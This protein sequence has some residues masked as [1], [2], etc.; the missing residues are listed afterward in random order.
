LG[1]LRVKGLRVNVGGVWK[2]LWDR[3]AKKPYTDDCCI[4]CEGDDYWNLATNPI[5]A[6]PTA[7]DDPGDWWWEYSTQTGKP[8]GDVS[9]PATPS[10]RGGVA[11]HCVRVLI[12]DDAE[13][14][15]ATYSQLDGEHV[16]GP[17]LSGTAV[18]DEAWSHN[19]CWNYYHFEFDDSRPGDFFTQGLSKTFTVD[20]DRLF[21]ALRPDL[22]SIPANTRHHVCLLCVVWKLSLQR[23]DAP[24]TPERIWYDQGNVRISPLARWRPCLE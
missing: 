5:T 23:M 22:C 17:W 19:S 14:D 15:G 7:G 21:A 4:C 3:V 24:T 6:T 8:V 1:E 10:Y 13:H 20:A 16:L 18:P 11:P 12:Y 2:P 9:A